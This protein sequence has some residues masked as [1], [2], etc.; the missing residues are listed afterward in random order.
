MSR[1]PDY[2]RPPLAAPL[3]WQDDQ[4]GELPAAVMA[5]FDRK[6]TPEQ[7]ELVRDYCQYYINA[8]CWDNN[9]YNDE[10]NRREL[11]EVREAIKRVKTHK[12]LNDWIYQCLDMG[13]DPL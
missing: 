5:Y 10:E 13:I 12:E 7:L 11:R 1:M 8:P 3:R 9:P 2:Y 6:Q 4:T